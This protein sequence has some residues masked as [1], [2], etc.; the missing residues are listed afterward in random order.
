METKLNIAEILKYKPEGTKLHSPLFGKCTFLNIY[1]SQIYISHHT[2]TVSSFYSNGT[3]FNFSEAEPLLFPSKEMC[4]WSKFAWKKGDVLI[5]NNGKREVL[6]ETWAN[7]SYTKFIGYHS[8][9]TYS[10]EEVEYDNSRSVFNTNDFI[11]IEAE[12]AAKTY[13]NTIEKHLGGKLNLE[14]LEIEKAQPEFKDG[15]IVSIVVQKCTHIAIFQ[16]REEEYIGFHAVLCQN[17]ELLLEKPYREDNGDIELRPANNS[18]KQQLFDALAKEGKA[19]DAEKKQIVDLPK[20]CEFKAFDKVLVRDN[21]SQKWIPDMYRHY[22]KDEYF[23][24][25]CFSSIYKYCIPYNEE[26]KHLLG[27]TDD[28]TL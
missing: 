13:I 4:D 15:D 7:D 6:F 11:G 16:S 23:P 8:L 28:Y 2:D 20:E 27:T 18:E 5:S 19:W 3:Y 26:T 12:E 9:I 24:H 17:D 1:N 22:N 10:D 14:T 25:N 21:S